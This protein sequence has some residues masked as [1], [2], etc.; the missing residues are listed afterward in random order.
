MKK[1]NLMVCG[2]LFIFSII[3]SSWSASAQ[4]T[5]KE[6]SICNA[7]FNGEFCDVTELGNCAVICYPN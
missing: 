7:E 3:G 5:I 1:I 6:P 2:L 4:E